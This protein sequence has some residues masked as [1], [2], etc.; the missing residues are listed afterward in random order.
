LVLLPRIVSSSPSILEA[1]LRVA[2][3]GEAL[4][5]AI[6]VGLPEP[7]LGPG[8]SNFEVETT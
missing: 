5:F 4:L 3:Q 8:A 6:E 7:A 2:T 1:D